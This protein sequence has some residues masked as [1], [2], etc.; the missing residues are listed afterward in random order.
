M[1]QALAVSGATRSGLSV[2]AANLNRLHLF[3]IAAD[4]DVLGGHVED[5]ARGQ[6]R[7][8]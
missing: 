2:C 5:V 3:R 7:V 8:G 4:T 1:R 6:L